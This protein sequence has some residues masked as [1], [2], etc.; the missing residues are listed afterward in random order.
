VAAATLGVV[1]ALDVTAV[2]GRYE[3]R[4]IL[5]ILTVGCLL[6][7]LG[8]GLAAVAEYDTFSPDPGSR[9]RARVGL[10]IGY[11]LLAVVLFVYA[12]ALN[13]A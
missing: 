2:A 7:G 5:P 4:M 13:T 12:A 9:Q 1:V 8:L 11:A 6:S 3:H 10:V